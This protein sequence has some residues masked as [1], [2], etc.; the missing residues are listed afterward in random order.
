MEIGGCKMGKENIQFTAYDNSNERM[1]ML[2]ESFCEQY[3]V[4]MHEFEK[5]LF[6]LAYQ[7]GYEDGQYDYKKSNLSEE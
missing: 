6:C 5:N 1:K 3:E 2:I 4:D 7:R